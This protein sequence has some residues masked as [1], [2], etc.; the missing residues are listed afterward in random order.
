MNPCNCQ[1]M[2]KDERQGLGALGS[3][4]IRGSGPWP[5]SRSLLTSRDEETRRHGYE[6]FREGLADALFCSCLDYG[7][8]RGRVH[9]PAGR[10]RD[11][12]RRVLGRILGG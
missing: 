2:T 3:R 6:L 12:R 5:I 8:A 1:M 9:Q 7:S 11:A 10:D 4:L